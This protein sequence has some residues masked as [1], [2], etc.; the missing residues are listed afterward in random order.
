MNLDFKSSQEI[1]AA[2]FCLPEY[3][4]LSDCD[5][6]RFH[7]EHFKTFPGAV[8]KMKNSNPDIFL[9]RVDEVRLKNIKK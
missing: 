6:W 5:L 1:Y 3:S 8:E 9:A 4:I 2:G 7:D